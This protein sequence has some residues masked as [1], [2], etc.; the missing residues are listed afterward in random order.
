LA[1]YAG[2]LREA[3]LEYKE[4]GRYRL[5]GALGDRLADVVAAAQ[6]GLAPVLLV[7]VPAT[8]QAARARHGDHM[9]RL[10]RRA[11]YTLR[12]RGRPAAVAYPIR[13]LP[14][15]DSTELS[16]VAR[17]AAAQEAFAVRP[18][19][20]A[21]VRAAVA[22]GA[23]VVLVDDVPTRELLQAWRLTI[24]LRRAGQSVE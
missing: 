11:A 5:A 12:A 20:T 22:A 1:G 24:T 10:A 14:R 21:A 7:P 19:R 16:A 15:P 6:P 8:A 4:R 23:S 17:A 13:A 3:V 18:R 9:A 2:A